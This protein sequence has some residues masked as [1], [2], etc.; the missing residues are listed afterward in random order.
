VNLNL[1][2]SQELQDAL[3]SVTGG[4]VPRVLR[5][6]VSFPTIPNEDTVRTVVASSNYPV[7]TMDIRDVV[8]DDTL[9]EVL[10]S[11][12]AAMG[13]TAACQVLNKRNVCEVDGP[14]SQSVVKRRQ[15]TQ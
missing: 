3:A 6:L 14:A 12:E 1:D 13:R 9:K 8:T 11:L 5:V 10:T 7:A 2:L 4:A 15:T